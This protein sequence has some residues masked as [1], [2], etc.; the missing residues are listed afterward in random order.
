MEENIEKRKE[1]IKKNPM[2]EDDVKQNPEKGIMRDPYV[3][4]NASGG[5][6]P[7]KPANTED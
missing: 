3:K 5:K 7:T 2:I 1:R 4:P 6:K